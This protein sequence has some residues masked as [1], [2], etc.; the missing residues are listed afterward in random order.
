MPRPTLED[1][2]AELGRMTRQSHALQSAHHVLLL[3][4]RDPQWIGQR[5]AVQHKMV[6]LM[7]LGSDLP[8]ELT[9]LNRF[10]GESIQRAM[11]H[12]VESLSR[13]AHVCGQDRSGTAVNL[14]HFAEANKDGSTQTVVL[15]AIPHALSQAD[16][17]QPSDENNRLL[18][19]DRCC[20]LFSH[21]LKPTL[22]PL[23]NSSFNPYFREFVSSRLYWI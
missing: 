17:G 3:V 6:Q 2:L 22:K 1:R 4:V 5:R 14:A 13:S 19:E 11:I 23:K 12:S 7:E 21:I 8:E 20:C 15:G 9:M 10:V 16:S 18:H